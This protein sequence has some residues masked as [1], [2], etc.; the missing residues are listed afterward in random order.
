MDSEVLV[1]STV[2][3]LYKYINIY[4]YFGCVLK[5]FP[6]LVTWDHALQFIL[7]YFVDKYIVCAAEQSSHQIIYIAERN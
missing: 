3:R 1:F 2:D 4:I 6:T 5:P 7:L